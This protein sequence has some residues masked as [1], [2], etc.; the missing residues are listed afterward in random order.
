MADNAPRKAG[1]YE[2]PTR[3][4]GMIIWGVVLLALIVL[5]IVFWLMLDSRVVIG[6]VRRNGLFFQAFPQGRD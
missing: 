1:E 4:K 2:R 6:Q 5:A 3:V